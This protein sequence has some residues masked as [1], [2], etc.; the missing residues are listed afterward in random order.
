MLRSMLSRRIQ[1]S[2]TQPFTEHSRSGYFSQAHNMASLH[3]SLTLIVA[4]R[5]SQTSLPNLH[6]LAILIVIGTYGYTRSQPLTGPHTATNNTPFTQPLIR[7]RYTPTP[8]L[9][10]YAYFLRYRSIKAK[11]A[12]KSPN[13]QVTRRTLKSVATNTVF[14]VSTHSYT[15]CHRRRTFPDTQT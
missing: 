6:M 15:N 5:A 13:P 7:T 9:R 2:V 12:L 10:K 4:L 1:S 14:S 8:I 3:P 11:T